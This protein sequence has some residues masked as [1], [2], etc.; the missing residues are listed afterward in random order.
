MR[1]GTKIALAT[2]GIAVMA[3]LALVAAR[4]NAASDLLAPLSPYVFRQRSFSMGTSCRI[5]HLRG[6][7]LHEVVRLEESRFAAEGYVEDKRWIDQ[8]HKVTFSKARGTDDFGGASIV[9]GRN[10]A[11]DGVVIFESHAPTVLESISHKASSLV[12][13]KGPFSKES[14]LDIHAV[15]KY[16]GE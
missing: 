4:R 8:H 16:L 2:G 13:L 14:D 3:G 11:L 5:T 6:V 15:R 1:R 7:D 10:V 9:D 12:G